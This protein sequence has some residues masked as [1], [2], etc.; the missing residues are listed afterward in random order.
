[1]VAT[2]TRN[3]AIFSSM[4]ATSSMSARTKGTTAAPTVQAIARSEI[5]ASNAGD[6]SSRTLSSERMPR[7]ATAATPRLFIP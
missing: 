6:A 5:Q 7:A 1:M 4:P 2:F 3:R